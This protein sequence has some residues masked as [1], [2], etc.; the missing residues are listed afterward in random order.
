VTT[1]HPRQLSELSRQELYDLIWSKPV[2]K[3]AIDFGISDVAI[4]KHCIKL[5]VPR[6]LRTYWAKMAAGGQP[7]KKPLTASI[8][9]NFARAAQKSV[10]TIL[11]LPNEKTPLHP[12]ATELIRAASKAE[13]DSQ[14]RAALRD[15]SLP[16]TTVS[17]ILA[18]RAAKAFHVILNGVEP[19]GISF[20][21]SLGSRDGGYFKKGHDRLYLR[22]E[23]DLLDATGTR[24]QVPWWK[25]QMSHCNPSG[26]LTFSVRVSDYHTRGVQQWFESAKAPL[27]ALLPEIVTGIRRHFLDAQNRRSQEAMESE[28]QRVEAER[29]WREWQVQ[30]AIRL[31]KE[32]EHKH[33]SV[34]ASLAKAREQNLL[35]AAELWR[36]SNS[37]SEFINACEQRWK[38]TSAELNT[39]QKTWL[40]WAKEYAN[41]VSPFSAG[42]PDPTCDGPFDPTTIS[43]GGPYPETRNFSR[44]QPTQTAPAQVPSTG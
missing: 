20:R 31:K 6:P 13:L 40:A 23:E 35:K 25:S 39:E 9:E 17:N 15:P 43:L 3:I 2:A 26:Y 11:P 27:E 44:H 30:E 1:T 18:E 33:V 16:E 21:K 34:L 32:K 24:L 8:Q 37:M 22:I 19:L 10:G 41:S 36:I 14:K 7:P 42:Y 38:N 5:N 12:L 29:R 28:R 4:T